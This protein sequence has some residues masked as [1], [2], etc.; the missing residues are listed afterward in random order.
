[1]AVEIVGAPANVSEALSRLEDDLWREAGEN[2]ASVILYGGLARGRF[3]PGKSDVNII[4]LLHE[5]SAAAINAISPALRAARRAVEVDPLVMTPGEIV[6]VAEAF[7]VKFLDIRDYHVVLVGK[8]PF[9]GLDVPRERLRIRVAQELRNLVLRLRRTLVVAGDDEVEASGSLEQA[10]RSFSL[11]L[12]VLLSFEGRKMPEDDRTAA[13][14]EAA[15]L[16]FGLDP[17][18]LARWAALRQGSASTAVLPRLFGDALAL[19]ARAVEIVDEMAE[20]KP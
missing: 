17:E 8:D 16:A 18:A 13:V 9:V 12:A 19:V 10:A 20:P 14:F 3:R 7:P 4:V 15:A 5:A 11:L 2:L 1:M 6:A